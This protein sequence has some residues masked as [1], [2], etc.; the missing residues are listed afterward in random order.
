MQRFREIK[1]CD[2][3]TVPEVRLQRH[4]TIVHLVFKLLVIRSNTHIPTLNGMNSKVRSLEKKVDEGQ[5][6]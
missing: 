4:L 2:T 3:T 6:H 5:T 1:G